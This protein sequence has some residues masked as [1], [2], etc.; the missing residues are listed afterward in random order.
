MRENNPES[1][2]NFSNHSNETIASFL[3]IEP[4]YKLKVDIQK[5]HNKC[6]Y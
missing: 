5:R 6:K 4:S 1:V 2:I 3:K